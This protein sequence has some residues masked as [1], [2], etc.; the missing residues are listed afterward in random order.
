MPRQ[1]KL[2]T[3]VLI[4]PE[5]VQRGFL[6]KI[7]QR[8]E[9]RGLQI[10][11]L[12]TINDLDPELATAYAS[13]EADEKA[14]LSGPCVGIVIR[15]DVNVVELVQKMVG[16]SAAADAI[17]TMRGD[18]CNGRNLIVCSKDVNEAS[19]EAMML[20]SPG[21]LLGWKHHDEPWVNETTAV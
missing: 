20:F 2:L 17:G 9:K 15:G 1:K 6:G 21:E 4:K 16:V 3:S 13:S 11:G 7:I 8:F 19:K 12:K 18:L 10:V 5:G 14:M